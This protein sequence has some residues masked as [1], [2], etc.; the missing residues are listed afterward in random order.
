MGAEGQ[1]EGLAPQG[2]VGSVWAHFC[3]KGQWGGITPGGQKPE[4][5]PTIFQRA[6]QSPT[7]RNCPAQNVS[8]AAT[9]MWFREMFF[10]SK[11]QFLLEIN[12]VFLLEILEML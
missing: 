11:R 2:T 7:A 4:R 8:S 5:L 9:E 10:P 12:E 3:Y 6:G 1:L